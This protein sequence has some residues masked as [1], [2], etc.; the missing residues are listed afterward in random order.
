VEDRTYINILTDTLRKKSNL[1]DRLIEI[2]TEQEGILV[3]EQPDTD[4]L[5]E[6]FSEKEVLIAQLNQLDD[7]FET[8]FQHVKDTLQSD[9]DQ[10]KDMILRLQEL[11]RLVME[12]STKLQTIEYKNTNKFQM[13]FA[14]KK[15]EIKDMNEAAAKEFLKDK[16]IKD[17][18]LTVYTEE[19]E[20]YDLYVDAYVDEKA[21]EDALNT[22]KELNAI[23]IK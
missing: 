2:S 14:G 15:K 7:G 8:V 18:Q 6:T 9:K 22:F 5:D 21:F 11:I 17:D 16:K 10:Y 20:N 12:K 3:S 4:R 23:E 19:N 13:F 1:L